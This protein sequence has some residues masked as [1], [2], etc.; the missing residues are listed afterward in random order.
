MA[1]ARL[2]EHKGPRK[3]SVKSIDMA[4]DS[5]LFRRFFSDDRRTLFEHARAVSERVLAPK[6]C[7]LHTGDVK[8]SD[9]LGEL[10]QF[11]GVGIPVEFGGT[12]SWQGIV[13]LV[14]LHESLAY[15]SASA[16]AFFDGNGLFATPLIL[17]GTA[18][19]KQ[20]YLTAL[21]SGEMVG[22][23]GLSD[24]NS[25][26]DLA[27][28]STLTFRRTDGSF[29]LNGSKTFVTN[30][31]IADYAVVFAKEV[32]NDERTKNITVFIV[33]KI[34]GP[35][36]GFV[37]E[38]PM[39]KMGWRASHTSIISID[40]LSV[41]QDD[42]IGEVGQGFKIAVVTLA[43][44]RLK[45]AAEALGLMERAY[46]EVVAFV[47]NRKAVGGGVLK[48]QDVIRIQVA[49]IAQLIQATRD[50][51]YN[52]AF[53]AETA[54]EGKVAAFATEAALAKSFAGRSLE[55]VASLAVRLHGGYGFT[56]EYPVSVIYADAPLYMIGEGADNVLLISA[57]RSL[58]G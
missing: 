27:N 14:I 6:T 19:Q 16:S 47:S 41:S 33:P 30:G 55:E 57:G 17:A 8:L 23:Y 52:A 24:L 51:V 18:A 20:R 53:L 25:G 11:M 36:N 35:E 21:A 31:P 9:L 45:I 29:L 43:Y 12:E 46:D 5:A 7:K 48:D 1:I 40:G 13:D 49:R 44:G 32:G 42:V 2:E 50:I 54:E 39:G 56:H 34:K 26:S 10:K 4:K 3:G 15:G 38:K 58:L 37:P 22:C 28:M